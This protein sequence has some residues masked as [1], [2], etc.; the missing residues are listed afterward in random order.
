MANRPKQTADSDFSPGSFGCHEA[1]HLAM[2]FGEMID[3]HLTSH[4]AVEANPVWRALAEQASR[5]LFDLY[6]AI[7]REH[8]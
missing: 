4:Q 7:G 6:Q 3:E 8:L 2:V 5:T 1:L